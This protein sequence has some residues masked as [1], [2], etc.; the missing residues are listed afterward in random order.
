LFD[1]CFSN[2]SLTERAIEA[3]GAPPIFEAILDGNSA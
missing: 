2:A 3:A 1:G